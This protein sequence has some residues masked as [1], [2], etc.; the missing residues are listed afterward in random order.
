MH[1][2]AQIIIR[3]YIGSVHIMFTGVRGLNSPDFFIL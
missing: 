3:N 1:A 2:V